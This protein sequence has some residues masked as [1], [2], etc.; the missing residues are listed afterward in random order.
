MKTF[1]SIGDYF[2]LYIPL[3]NVAAMDGSFF[4]ARMKASVVRFL[5]NS[6]FLMGRPA[7]VTTRGERDIP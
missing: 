1:A 2:L 5:A 4:R 7:C 6:P 3:K